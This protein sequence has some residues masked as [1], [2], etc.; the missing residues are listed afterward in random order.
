M[1]VLSVLRARRLPY[2]PTYYLWHRLDQ[3][4]AAIGASFGELGLYEAESDEG[5]NITVLFE[6]NL[7]CPIGA[8]I[9]GEMSG[10]PDELC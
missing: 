3:P 9:E 6:V 10:P 1:R 5:S 8:M 2:R 7:R 4:P